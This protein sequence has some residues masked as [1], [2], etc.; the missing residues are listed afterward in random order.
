MAGNSVSRRCK[1]PLE[2]NRSNR[3][4]PSG[5][6]RKTLRSEKS[7]GQLSQ[8]LKRTTEVMLPEWFLR[9]K[10]RLRAG[11]T[12]KSTNFKVGNPRL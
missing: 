6:C 1:D 11:Y 3:S 12:S 8:L 10:S 2:P 4:N 7:P 9:E 5:G